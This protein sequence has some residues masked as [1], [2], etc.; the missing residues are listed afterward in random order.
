[1]DNVIK[2]TETNTTETTVSADT[3]CQYADCFVTLSGDLLTIGNNSIKRCYRWNNGNLITLSLQSGSL[4]WKLNATEPDTI[5]PGESEST[6]AGT[7]T[8]RAVAQTAQLPARLEICVCHTLGAL[9]IKRRFRLYPGVAAI[10]VDFFLRGTAHG[11]WSA[12]AIAAGTLS[13]IEH[14][15]AAAEG[16]V[17]RVQLDCLHLDYRHLAIRSV[18]FFDITDRRNNLL[19]EQSYLSFRQSVELH[20]ELLL[21]K[22]TISPRH[23]FILREAPC[24]DVQLANPG[25][26]FLATFADIRTY[27]IGLGIKDVTPDTWVRGYG[28]VIGTAPTEL[29]LLHALH[30][31]KHHLRRSLPRRDSMILLNTW[32]DRSQD[33]SIGEEFARAEIAAGSRLGVTHFQLDDGW[34]LGRSSNSAFGGTLEGIW[35]QEGY[36]TVDPTRFPNGLEPLVAAAAKVGIELCLWFNPSKDNSYANWQHDAACLIGLYRRYGIRTFKIDGVDIPDKQA[37]LNLR[38]MLDT[39]M[40][41]TNGEAVFNF[42]VTAGRRVGYHYF[43]EYGNK[44]LENRYT[45][46]SNYYPHWTL[47]NL[48]LLSRYVPAQS[49]QIEFLNC[50]RNPDKYPATDPLA[51]RHVPFGY[52]FGVTIMAQP[53]AWFEASKLPA[54]AFKIAPMIKKYRAIQERIHSGVILPVGSEP[55]GT[56]WSGFHSALKT[57]GYLAIYR[58]LNNTPRATITV[59]GLENCNL[60]ITRLIGQGRPLTRKVTNSGTINFTMPAPFTFGLFHY[61]IDQ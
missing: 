60:K 39:V 43:T 48:W 23:L 6:S 51:P 21:V 10:A 29:E 31:Y 5:I 45:D 54:E 20:G 25:C 14:A 12:S 4:I 1:M 34:Q 46:W 61:K 16:N 8:A 56:T 32:G 2:L 30:N 40:A 13:Q 52:C 7:L 15:K 24:S 26:E 35:H 55:D 41:A 44:F 58:E 3:T 9:E 28:Y 27:G 17:E 11:N 47:R 18:Q 50:W 33:R 53:L 59:P 42:D 22:D 57:Q 38:A 49:L 37:D 36:W 19:Q